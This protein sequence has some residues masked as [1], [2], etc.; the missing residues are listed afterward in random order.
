MFGSGRWCGNAPDQP[1]AAK[2]LASMVF[3]SLHSSLRGL[4]R[5]KSSG[6]H[7]TGS[8][9]QLQARASEH[10]T[11]SIHCQ[12][13]LGLEDVAN[14]RGVDVEFGGQLVEA[15]RARQIDVDDLDD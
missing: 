6:V 9:G 5:H 3:A 8:T 10:P 12:H 7:E 4:P 1:S 14:P 13:T 11:R 2:T 15:A